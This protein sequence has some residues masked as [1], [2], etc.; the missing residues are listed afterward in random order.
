MEAS[1]SSWARRA[2]GVKLRRALESVEERPPRGRGS[3]ILLAVGPLPP[4]INGLSKAFQYI[5][6]QL[7]PRGWQ[8][9]VVDAADRSAPRRGSAF[10]WSRAREVGRVVGGV[11]KKVSRADVLY[12]TI[13]QS[14]LGFAKDLL[15]LN[16][17]FA[18]GRPAV[19]HMH[20]GNFGGFYSALSAPERR[21]VR[22]ALERV[23]TIVVL[24]P[25]LRADFRMSRRWET[26]TVAIANACDGAPGCAR[27]HPGTSWRLLF[28]SN[29]LPSKGYRDVLLAVADL[30]RQRPSLSVRLV[31]AGDLVPERAFA[32]AAAQRKDLEGLVAALPSN[33][34]A[35][36][37]GVV[38][39]TEKE[40]LLAS[41]DVFLLPT[42]YINEGQPIALMEAMRAGLPVIA[43]RWRGIP[44]TL[45]PAMDQLLVDARDP[46]LIA[47]KLAKLV[48]EPALFEAQSQ[49]SLRQGATFSLERHLTALDGVLR[50]A[51]LV[52][53]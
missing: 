37:A 52:P 24:T 49:E 47:E 32:D 44:E 6:E 8:V 16:A 18:A 26:Q 4:P 41:S 46:S 21:I 34:Q 43:T 30:G 53:S 48:D 19:I 36:Y 31:L 5:A 10:S 40:N 7:P 13:S 1:R 3:R 25:S 12:L 39:G 14:R 51:L 11:I 29:L 38:M 22:A 27:R 45:S 15:I 42:D 9:E 35:S 33:V 23:R 17:A 2:Q 20:G 50:S 28:L